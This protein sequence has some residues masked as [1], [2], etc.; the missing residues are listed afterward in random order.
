[1]TLQPISKNEHLALLYELAGIFNSSL[2]LDEV[3]T[4]VVDEVIK[5]TGAQ[6]GFIMLSDPDAD[7]QFIFQAARDSSSA[8]LND[9]V[10]QVSKT[11]AR[12]V[13]QNQKPSLL[14]DA[15]S[16]K[17]LEGVHTVQ[18]LNLHSVLCVPLIVKDKSIGVIY[19]DNTLKKGTFNK[20]H[21]ELLTAIAAP[22]ATAIENARLFTELEKTY[23]TTLAGWA[24]AMDLRDSITENHCQRVTDMTLEVAKRDPKIGKDMLV[25]IRRG[26]MLHDI[27]K[28]GIPDSIL[29]KPGPLSPEEWVVMRTHP[30]I[31][32]NLL[33]NIPYLIPALTIP[34][35]HHERWDGLGYPCGLRGEEI[36]RE[37]RIFSVVDVY[38]ALTSARPYKRAMDKQ[39]SIQEILKDIGTRFDPEIVDNFVMYINSIDED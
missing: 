28:M 10:T 30:Q 39:S 5:E 13:F 11:I 29:Q 2:K 22:A 26:A 16:D 24:R 33:N 21:L 23:D 32:F 3:L 4:N 37:A 15:L 6:R 8:N 19:V 7:D 17:S 20:N 38:D 35:S 12:D 14:F 1:M 34:Y 18:L 27:G 9:P 36:P 31:A 25:H